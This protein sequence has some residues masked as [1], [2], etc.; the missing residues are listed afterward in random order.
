[1]VADVIGGRS[2]ETAHPS[3]PIVPVELTRDERH[4]SNA[5]IARAGPAEVCSTGNTCERV[6]ASHP[7]EG[8]DHRPLRHVSLFR[9]SRTRYVGK[10]RGGAM[11]IGRQVREEPLVV[12]DRELLPVEER[13]ATQRPARERPAAEPEPVPIEQ[14]GR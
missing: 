6:E 14:P 8:M 7:L 11:N 3:L 13:P 10:Q 5:L 1:M 12:P 9:S 4:R 2:S